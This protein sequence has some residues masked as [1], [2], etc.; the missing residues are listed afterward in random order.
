MGGGA[1]KGLSLAREKTKGW[2][3]K[4]GD[5]YFFVISL[6]MKLRNINQKN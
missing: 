2:E 5:F 3:R 4:K 6:K 1:R